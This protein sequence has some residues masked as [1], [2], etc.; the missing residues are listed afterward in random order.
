MTF[1]SI[2]DWQLVF[3]AVKGN[4]QDVRA[5]WYKRSPSR[6]TP[7]VG[8]IPDGFDLDNWRDT[9]KH[10]RSPLIDKWR[11]LSILKVR[12]CTVFECHVEQFALFIIPPCK[13]NTLTRAVEIITDNTI[14][15][16]KLDYNQ[17]L[18]HC[19]NLYISK[20]IWVEY[21]TCVCV[22]VSVKFYEIYGSSNAKHGVHIIVLLRPKITVYI[23]F[24]LV[25]QCYPQTPW[26]NLLRFDVLLTLLVVLK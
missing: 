20:D 11:Y 5:A 3:H 14:E 12:T 8:C 2:S 7:A 13:R 26:E 1:T 21:S 24:A 17:R 15:N 25:N 6:C 22:C 18:M 19:V 10:L 23:I 9:R 4:K 16:H